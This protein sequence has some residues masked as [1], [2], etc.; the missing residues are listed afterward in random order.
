MT[1][2][3]AEPAARPPG[4]ARA[5]ALRVVVVH[6]HYLHPGGEDRVFEAEVALLRG[7]GHRV[8][9][10]TAHNRDVGRIGAAAAGLRALWNAGAGRELERLLRRERPHV[11]HA[12]NTF[13]LLSAAVYHAA[14]RA[15]AAVVQTLHNF[16][17]ICPNALLFSGGGPCEACVGR[18]VPWPG[19]A[20]GCYHDSRAATCAVAASSAIHRRAG[21][22]SVDVY[23]ALSAFARRRFVAGGLPAG[24]VVVR[25]NFLGDDPGAGAH[26]GG[27]AL[28]AGRL[29]AEKGV[30]TMVDGWAR[31]GGAVPLVVAG[32][33]PL[34]ALARRKTP[35][36]AWA[37]A[38][39]RAGVL[40]LMGDAR[41]LVFPSECPENFPLALVEAFAT[42]LPVVAAD[43]GAA[44]ALVRRH[45]AGWVYP[46]GDAA[47]L[48]AAVRAALDD[49]R[50]LA[51]MGAHARAAFQA[52]YTAECG[53][54][55]LVGAYQRALR[56]AGLPVPAEAP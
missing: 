46:R 9:T 56:H 25:P 19:I 2:A 16:R 32:E 15:G 12:H 39:D 14:R 36:V 48:A 18:A 35:G 47:A 42:G 26:Q 49:P 27:F 31:L 30:G 1:A 3:T 6:E 5:R 8:S 44:A 21:E 22:H 55:S 43:G 37:G 51:A 50:S 23:L 20:R 17:F 52:H 40:R 53:Y 7:R 28:Y 4:A 38:I 45:G 13:P 54:R 33:G 34:E 41:L 24:R 11:V 10:F 29:S